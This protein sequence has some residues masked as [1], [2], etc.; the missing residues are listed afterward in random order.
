MPFISSGGIVH[1]M[2]SV[3][4]P[5]FKIPVVSRR[6]PIKQVARSDGFE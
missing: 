3:I 4:F 5:G 2:F 6:R 1:V